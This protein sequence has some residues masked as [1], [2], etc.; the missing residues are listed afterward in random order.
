MRYPHLPLRP[1]GSPLGGQGEGW[2]GDG[3]SFQVSRDDAVE[4]IAIERSSWLSFLTESSADTQALTPK[5]RQVL[6]ALDD[7]LF[8]V[9]NL[10]D[11][12][13]LAWTYAYGEY[14]FLAVRHYAI[15]EA[16]DLGTNKSGEREATAFINKI[17]AGNKFAE[18]PAFDDMCRV[19]GE[20]AQITRMNFPPS[21]AP[22]P[23]LVTRL[24]TRYGVTLV[25]ERAVVLLD[26]VGF[27]LKSPLEQVAML[28]SLSYTVNSAYRQLLS[29]DVQ[30]NFARTTT[31]DGFYIWN[32]SRTVQANIALYKLMI[33]ILTDNAIA[34][35]KAKRFPVPKLRAAYHI[36]EHY[37]FYQVEALNPTTFAYIVGQVTID[38][39]RMI[40][41]A[42][43]GQILIGDF[44]VELHDSKTGQGTRYG[45]LDFVEKT[46]VTLDDLQG[47]EVAQDTI[48]KIRCYLTG[49][50]DASGG[51]RANQ[52]RIKDKHGMTRLAYNAK[53]NIH[54]THAE[55]IF[56]GIQHKYLH[57]ADGKN[58]IWP[59]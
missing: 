43:P 47:L 3:Y 1:E 49:E 17:L 54:C 34:Q 36:G 55:P 7:E 33:L 32:R 56:L 4:E 35:K 11:N 16:F 24:V 37:E 25:R 20:A 8:K 44:N 13:I 31:G 15:I 53:I 58:S 57:S 2:D 9:W 5:L 21:D 27:S 45:S 41:K 48:E 38:L 29:K 46:A 52:Y 22:T 18:P 39:F 42:L 12:I 19:L 28:N 50:N 6:A 23:E 26:A 10:G 59:D 51:F 14:R 30:I 40:E